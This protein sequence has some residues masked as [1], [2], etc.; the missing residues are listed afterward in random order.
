MTGVQTCA[1]PISEWLRSLGYEQDQLREREGILFAVRHV[2]LDF[3]SPARFNDLLRVDVTLSRR[4]GASLDFVQ[5]VRRE[6]D[7]ALCCRG[8]VKIACVNAETLR[9][10]RIPEI[11]LAEIADVL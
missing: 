1:L 6:S 11:L 7:G 4:G 9:P 8:L 10:N 2:T 5:E 3:L